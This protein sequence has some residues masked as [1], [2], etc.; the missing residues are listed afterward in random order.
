MLYGPGAGSGPTASSVVSDILNLK[1]LSMKKNI[2]KDRFIDPLLSFNC[3]RKCHVISSEEIRKK[4]YLRIICKDTPGVIGKIGN[5]FGNNDVSI[6]S[7]IQLDAR[8]N[9]AEIV[10]ITHHVSNGN[11]DISKNQLN[12][13]PEVKFIAAQLNCI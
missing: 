7:I 8:E 11:I 13:L 6:E 3:W 1:A 2:S 10:V 9:E 5:I 12:A 4:N